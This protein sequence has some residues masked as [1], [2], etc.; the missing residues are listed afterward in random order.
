[1]LTH[2]RSSTVLAALQL[3]A[4]RGR[5]VEV[6]C[7]ES[8]PSYEGRTAA[9]ALSQEGIRTRLITDSAAAH[10]LGRVNLVM[11]GADS[12]S[13]DGLVNKMGTYAIALAAR[14]RGV[15]FYALCGTEKFLP[16]DYP[17]FRIAPQDPQEVWPEHPQGVE[18]LN[19]YFDV[20]PLE[21]VSA[22]IT[23]QGM[24][25]PGELQDIVGQ[26]KLLETLFD[27]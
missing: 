24:L 9:A 11:V 21:Y 25:A 7:T 6:V 26:L 20:T 4:T 8:R 22:V 13:G 14:D 12:V 23:E 27:D 18:V 5:L 10:F 2:S 3:A 15:P 16:T 19:L 17:Y 1:V